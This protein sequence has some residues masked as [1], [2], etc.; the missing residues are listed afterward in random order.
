MFFWLNGAFRDGAEEG[1]A[2]IDIADR[3]FLLGDGVFETIL[4]VDGAPAF[5]SAHLRRMR[6]GAAGIGISANID[7]AEV[8]GVLAE[9]VRRNDAGVGLA[10]ARLTL[11]RGAG[12]R[13]LVIEKNVA[14]ST[15]LVTVSAYGPPKEAAAP[16]A[17]IVSSH[18]R[19]ELSAASRWKTLNYLDNVLARVEAA[20]V[21][22]M[23]RSCSIARGVRRVHRRRIFL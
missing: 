11:T 12:P 10:S 13:G 3:G 22:P 20:A 18:R 17:L 7:E 2:A 4:L 21:G 5:L 14:T 6:A 23:M 15:F 19:N 9:L 1:T 16:A 8:A